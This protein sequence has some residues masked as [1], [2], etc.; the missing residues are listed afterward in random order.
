M[1]DAPRPDRLWAVVPLKSPQHAKT[2]LADQLDAAQRR[3]LLFELATRVIRALQATDAVAEVAVATA[4][5]EIAEFAQSLGAR[6]ILQ[7]AETGTAAAFSAVIAQ[8]Q[9]G[10]PQAL[11]MIAGDLPLVT[12]AAIE[13]LCA[14][15]FDADVVVVPDRHRIGTNALL[16]SPPSAI[17]PLFGPDSLHRHLAAARRRELRTRVLESDALSLDLDEPDDLDELRRRG[18]DLDDAL[19]AALAGVPAAGSGTG[20]VPRCR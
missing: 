15:A 14:A 10:Q 11:L 2:R 9:A 19:R 12:P 18:S 1:P 20:A 13:T 17:T 3:W 8:L 6:P 4:S 7:S 16:C 5:K